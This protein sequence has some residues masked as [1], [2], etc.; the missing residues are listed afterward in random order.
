MVNGD[1]TV[2]TA[3][4]HVPLLQVNA[5]VSIAS[6][7]APVMMAE[8]PCEQT[9]RTLI[10]CRAATVTDAVAAKLHVAAVLATANVV[11]ADPALTTTAAVPATSNP[12]DAVVS[13]VVVRDPPVMMTAPLSV[14]G[15][16]LT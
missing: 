9:A 3:V 6:V 11:G 10:V 13:A 15:P 12:V 5:L 1:A 7:P 16:A 14:V 2:V 4:L 8:P